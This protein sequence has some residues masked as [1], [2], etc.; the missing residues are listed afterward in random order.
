MCNGAIMNCKQCAENLTALEDG[1]LSASDSERVRSHLEVCVS[2]ADEL[3]SLKEAADFIDPHRR[4]LEPRP[5]SWNLIRARISVENSTNRSRFFTLNRWGFA[6]ASLAIFSILAIGY[7]QYRQF[8]RKN[9]DNYI[10]RYIQDRE[11]RRKTQFVRWIAEAGASI[12]NPYADNPFVEIRASPVD[13][14][15]S[16]DMEDQ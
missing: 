8:E 3:R 6:L 10:S 14:P 16:I 13:N 15:F 9:L 1:E 12:E 4:E 2:C 11:T 5:E 7:L